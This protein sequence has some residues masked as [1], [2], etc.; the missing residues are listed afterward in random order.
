MNLN[1]NMK[2]DDVEV[3]VNTL[4]MPKYDT[5]LMVECLLP[6]NHVEIYIALKSTQMGVLVVPKPLIAM[7]VDQVEVVENT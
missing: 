6:T 5:F 7:K 1:N 4:F 3:V 2:S